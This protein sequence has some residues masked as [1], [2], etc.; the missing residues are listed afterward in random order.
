MREPVARHY[1]EY[2]MSVRNCQDLEG[3]LN[4]EGLLFMTIYSTETLSLLLLLLILSLLLLLL[5]LLLS[6]LSLLL[7]L[8]LS[9]FTLRSSRRKIKNS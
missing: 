3:H 5:L 6:L 7:L 4:R 2:Q 9:L 1:S 8:L